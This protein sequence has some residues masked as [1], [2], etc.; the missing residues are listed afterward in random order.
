MIEYRK[1]F[2]NENIYVHNPKDRNPK[3]GQPNPQKARYKYVYIWRALT[4]KGNVSKYYHAELSNNWRETNF[5]PLPKLPKGYTWKG[6]YLY[7]EYETW[8][9]VKEAEK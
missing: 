4:P 8:N 2:P 6:P 1:A 9:D 5:Y 3:T 7:G